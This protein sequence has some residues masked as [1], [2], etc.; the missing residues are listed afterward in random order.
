M[1]NCST[2]VFS[3]NGRAKGLYWVKSIIIIDDN[4]FK[5]LFLMMTI[6]E[7]AD[8]QKD[9]NTEKK[10]GEKKRERRG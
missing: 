2:S 7:N 6:W 1:C 10:E 9:K 8:E 3:Q 4:K 5:V